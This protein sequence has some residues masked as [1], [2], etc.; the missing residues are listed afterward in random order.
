M[1]LKISEN[2]Q[3]SG[4]DLNKIIKKQLLIRARKEESI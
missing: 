2:I 1:N 4:G 3:I